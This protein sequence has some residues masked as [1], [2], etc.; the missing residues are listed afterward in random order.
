[1]AWQFDRPESGE[2]MVQVFRRPESPVTAEDLKLRGLDSA[3]RYRVTNM[4]VPGVRE[5]TGRD[6][7]EKGL[8][9]VLEKQP[10]SAIISY[11][12]VN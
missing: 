11:K 1:M 10:D 2:G 4:D 6:L 5:M 12:R 8:H 3:A 9:V 7:M